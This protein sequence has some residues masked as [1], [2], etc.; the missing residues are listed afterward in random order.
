MIGDIGVVVGLLHPMS[1]LDK[2]KLEAVG[3]SRMFSISDTD[4]YCY[5][6]THVSS[7]IAGKECSVFQGLDLPPLLALLR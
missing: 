5:S 7:A 1:R 3:G 6:A 2:S 4:G